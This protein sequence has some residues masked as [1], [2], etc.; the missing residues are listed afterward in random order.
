M[1][2]EHARLTAVENFVAQIAHRKNR[3]VGTAG[4]LHRHAGI[5]YFADKNRVVAHLYRIHQRALD[6]SRRF[7]QN[8]RAERS[9]AKRLAT[10]AVAFA[11]ERFEKR[12]GLPFLILAKNIQCERLGLL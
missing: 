1:N 2:L 4:R 9:F 10:D 12:E 7:F 3:V 11:F 8:R 5:L 6:K